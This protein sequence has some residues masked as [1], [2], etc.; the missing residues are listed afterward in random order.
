ML[1]KPGARRDH[2]RAD[3]FIILELLLLFLVAANPKAKAQI[4]TSLFDSLWFFSYPSKIDSSEPRRRKKFLFPPT[5]IARTLFNLFGGTSENKFLSLS[6][7][8]E[9]IRS[10]IF[11]TI[12]L[13]ILFDASWLW[14][15]KIEPPKRVFHLRYLTEQTR[16][17]KSIDWTI[18]CWI[19]YNLRNQFVYLSPLNSRKPCFFRRSLSSWSFKPYNSSLP[20]FFL[21]SSTIHFSKSRICSISCVESIMIKASGLGWFDW[22]WETVWMIFFAIL[23][24]S[25][26][27]KTRETN[28]FIFKP[29]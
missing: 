20:I 10:K 6:S 17:Q 27:R 26:P 3:K 7:W 1:I 4:F 11:H 16:K 8:T 12:A 22:W 2:L 28:F 13:L 14:K 21:P 25:L 29:N 19:L 5:S 15:W 23:P 18:Y 9:R 24:Q